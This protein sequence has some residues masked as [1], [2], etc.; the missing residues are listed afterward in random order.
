MDGSLESSGCY[1]EPPGGAQRLRRGAA[2]DGG[3]AELLP[4]VLH[5]AEEEPLRSYNPI[6]IDRSLK[7]LIGT[8]Q[9]CVPLR[10]GSLVVEC[11]GIQQMSQLLHSGCLSDGVGSVQIVTSVVQPAGAGAVIYRVPLDLTDED[12][13]EILKPQKV[14]YMKGF[15]NGDSSCSTTVFLQF[16]SPQLPAEVGVGYLLFGVKSYIPEPLRCFDCNRFGHVASNCRGG[17]RCSTCG[18]ER[19]WKECSAPLEECPNCAG[20]RGASD[21]VCPRYTKEAVVLKMEHTQNLT[22]AEACKQ[23][24]GSQFG[25]GD[26]RFSSSDFPPL[27]LGSSCGRS[28]DMDQ[29]PPVNGSYAHPTTDSILS[30]R[31]AGAEGCPS[32]LMLGS[33]VLFL[34]FLAD[35]VDQALSAGE[36]NEPVD[37]FE[38][39]TDAAGGRMGLP[40]EAEQLKALFS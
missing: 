35:V 31:S 28:M 23:Y 36:R 1:G 39:V 7:K 40:V 12:L 38:I 10:D 20:E 26:P 27:P 2:S 5:N 15:G 18:G 14:A 19:V 30:E 8:Y 22:C 21:G 29:R 34:A 9:A 13:L 17:Q 24:T 16:S 37:L 3:V 25:S 6:F 4:V 32:G 11:E 33:P